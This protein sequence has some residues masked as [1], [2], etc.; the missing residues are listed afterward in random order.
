MIHSRK[1]TCQIDLAGQAQFTILKHFLIIVAALPKS[2]ELILNEEFSR[3][4]TPV[5]TY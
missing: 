3:S 2:R 1:E 4:M 5:S